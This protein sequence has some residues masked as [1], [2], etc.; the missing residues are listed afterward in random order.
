MTKNLWR[1]LLCVGLVACTVDEPGAL[2]TETS[3][4]QIGWWY[5]L[6]R[7]PAR[8]IVSAPSACSWGAG[9]M[10]IVVRASDNHVW[11][12]NGNSIDNAQHGWNTWLDMGTPPNVAF[13]GKPAIASRTYGALDIY[14]I[15]NDGNVW[16]RWFWSNAWSA[17]YNIGKPANSALVGVDVAANQA[18]GTMH[19]VADAPGQ[20]R[21]AVDDRV[22]AARLA[23]SGPARRAGRSC[24]LGDRERSGRRRSSSGCADAASVFAASSHVASVSYRYSWGVNIKRSRTGPPRR[25][26]VR[27][28]AAR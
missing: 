5:S 14:A 17:W 8:T 20:Q 12:I 11:L 18:D 16:N 7:P 9:R 25:R 26:R 24:R 13:I 28:R 15:G 4:I 22:A 10:D 3:A 27:R 23:R 2:E 1:C 6:G 19:M 21:P